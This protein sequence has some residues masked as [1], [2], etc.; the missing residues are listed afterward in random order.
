MKRIT[1]VLPSTSSSDTC[2]KRQLCFFVAV[3]PKNCAM[4]QDNAPA[5]LPLR[6]LNHVSRVCRDVAASAAFYADVLGFALIK[7][8]ESFDFDGAW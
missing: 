8:P 1:A 6:S 3:L 2:R 7:R 4:L 5:R